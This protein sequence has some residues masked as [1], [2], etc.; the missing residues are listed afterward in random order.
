MPWL[1]LCGFAVVSFFVVMVF[2]S[3]FLVG[4]WVFFYLSVLLFL[5]FVVCFL[6]LWF[7]V[8]GCVGVGGLWLGVLWWGSVGWF[9]LV[10]LSS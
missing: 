1:L 4:G 10:L 6:G 3:R 8:G 2:L 9:L 5:V 7:C